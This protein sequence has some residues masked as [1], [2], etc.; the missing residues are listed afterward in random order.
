[1]RT[2]LITASLAGAL[3]LA[4]TGQASAATLGLTIGTA[5]SFTVTLDGT[6]QTPAFTLGMTATATNGAFNVTASATSFT[7]STYTLASPTVTGLVAGACTGGGC[8]T[9]TNTIASYPVLLTAAAQKI[10]SASTTAKG[11]IP[12]TANLTLSVPDNSFSSAY[13]RTVTLTIASGP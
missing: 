12:V 2:P 3:A 5:P 8:V 13:V 7:V 4:F 6:D 9:P 10:Y 11:S 1:M